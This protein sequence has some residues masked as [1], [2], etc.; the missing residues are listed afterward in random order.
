M[1]YSFDGY[2][3]VI[4]LAVGERLSSSLEQ[5]FAETNLKGAWVSGLGGASNIT[6]GFYDLGSKEYNWRIIEDLHEITALTG[7][8]AK[9]DAGDMVFHLHGSFANKHYQVIGG[10]IKDFTAGATVEL[11]VQCTRKP[12][13]RAT[14]PEVGL[15]V[16][17]LNSD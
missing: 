1:T 17:Q 6:I 10:H 2:N 11:F 5:F 13:M 4:K 12:L 9:N 3:Y 16:L 15:Q 8:F 14:D 7:N